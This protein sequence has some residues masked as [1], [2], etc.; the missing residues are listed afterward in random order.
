MVL[1]VSS[2]GLLPSLSVLFQ[3]E[4]AA[5]RAAT[6]MQA[7]FRRYA[8]YTAYQ[9]LVRAHQYTISAAVHVRTYRHLPEAQLQL[10]TSVAAYC[11]GST[12]VT[13]RVY[14]LAERS[15]GWARSR[16]R[17]AR[18]AQ[19]RAACVIQVKSASVHSKLKLA[20]L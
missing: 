16:G 20:P 12:R 4:A 18:I 9:A 17:V 11:G 3:R 8:Q 1:A 10:L 6:L 15:R 14:A 13:K 5:Q 19:R 2:A 7:C